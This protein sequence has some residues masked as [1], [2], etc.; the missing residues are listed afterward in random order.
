[1]PYTGGAFG[2]TISDYYDDRQYEKDS[3]SALQLTV[4]L[5]KNDMNGVI[6]ELAKNPEAEAA[7]GRAT[8]YLEKLQAEGN[9]GRLKEKGLL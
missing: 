6:A 7:F 4:A 2:M 9:L 8:A 5:A 3:R 1:M